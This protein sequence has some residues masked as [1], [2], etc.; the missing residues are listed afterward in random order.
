[1][2]QQSCSLDHSRRCRSPTKSRSI[3][4]YSVSFW[5]CSQMKWK[6]MNVYGWTGSRWRY[7]MSLLVAMTHSC[8]ILAYTAAQWQMEIEGWRSQR[9]ISY[10][11]LRWWYRPGHTAI[12]PSS[13][14][15]SLMHWAVEQL[16]GY[17]SSQILFCMCTFGTPYLLA[18]NRMAK[19][20]VLSIK[21]F[22]IWDHIC[23]NHY[24][25]VFWR[26]KLREIWCKYFRLQ[27]SNTGS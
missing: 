23:W 15:C 27:R 16:T 7:M 11:R 14:G 18:P 2:P 13:E 8:V 19:I 1:M 20:A 12:D 22:M 6:V 4:L 10:C 5:G 3:A 24:A 21:C 17:S 9:A 25:E 26:C